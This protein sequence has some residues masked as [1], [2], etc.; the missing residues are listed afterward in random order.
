[1]AKSV[2]GE[3]EVSTFRL[4]LDVGNSSLKWRLM[5]G[6]Q[7]LGG[8]RL[9]DSPAALVELLGAGPTVVH[10]ASVRSEERNQELIDTFVLA[11]VPFSFARSQRECAGVTNSYADIEKMGVDRWLVMVAAFADC[12]GPC[13]V[14]DAG[15]A[16]TIDVV[17]GKGAHLGGYIIAGAGLSAKALADHT[18]RVRF[19]GED[20]VSLV[21]GVD[22]EGCVHHGK[23]LAQL[24]AVMAALQQAEVAIGSTAEVYITGGDAPALISLA[25]AQGAGW[26]YREELVLDGLAVVMTAS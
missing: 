7:R 1:M 2:C 16:L 5:S 13:V 6:A 12:G 14:V 4:E 19:A 20:R 10:I 24:G 22:T 25:G 23:W 26:Q 21:P 3:H 18:G 17:S 9:A 8:G 15:T 11:G